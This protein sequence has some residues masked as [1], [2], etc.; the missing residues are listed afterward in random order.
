[1]DAILPAFL[2]KLPSIV[3]APQTHDGH[4]DSLIEERMRRDQ[5]MR[6]S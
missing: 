2:L 4:P 3:A 6:K 1:M 5:L